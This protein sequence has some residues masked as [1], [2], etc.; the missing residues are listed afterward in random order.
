MKSAVFGVA[1][2]V[3]VALF[4][5]NGWACRNGAPNCSPD[6]GGLSETVSEDGVSDDIQTSSAQVDVQDEE[7]VVADE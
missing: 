5:E 7:T 4:A 2:A 3:L 6:A 1:L